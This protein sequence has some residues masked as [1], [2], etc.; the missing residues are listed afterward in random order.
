M[1]S[2]YLKKI[3][4]YIIRKF[5]GTYFYAIG[6]II[7]IAIIFDISEK[8]DDFIE[9]K[10]PLSAILFDYY[11]NFIPFFVNLFSPLFTF[12]AVIYF[13]SRMAANTEIIAILNAGVSFRRLLRPYIVSAVFIMLIAFFFANF[14]IPHVNKGRIAFEKKYIKNPYVNKGINIHF[15][16][17]KETYYYVESFDNTANQGYRFSMEKMNE[18]GLYYKLNA[19]QAV[20]DSVTHKWHLTDC[21]ERW[22]NGLEEKIVKKDAIDTAFDIKPVDF[23]RDMVNIETM[24]WNDL[25]KYLNREKLRGS[26][27]I[28]TYEIEQYQRMIFPLASIV[29]TLI[30]VSLSSRKVRGGIGVN[31]ALGILF[32]FTFILF[33]K[34]STVFATSGNLP[35]P[36]AALIPIVLYSVLAVYL[37]QKAPK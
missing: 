25:R 1:F 9:K 31:L 5:L 18:K 16:Q 23:A 34:I 22:I 20:W 33:M 2:K 21:F 28:K 26:D 29:L 10:A 6:L 14:L 12:I 4:W 7:A 11:L 35:A 8:I 19:E 13:T 37:I 15:Q 27:R 36:I 17:D 3:D 30:G 32:A 24:N